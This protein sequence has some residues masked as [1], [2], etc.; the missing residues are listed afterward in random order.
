MDNNP[1]IVCERCMITYVTTDHSS[2][3]TCK[4]FICQMC[5][6]KYGAL[7]RKCDKTKCDTCHKQQRIR[8]MCSLCQKHVC[9]DCF[10][11]TDFV[12]EV[13]SKCI[14]SCEICSKFLSSISNGS[15]TME[16]P[17]LNFPH[18]AMKYES[19]HGIKLE[20]RLYV[21]CLRYQSSTYKFYVF[22]TKDQAMDFADKHNLTEHAIKECVADDSETP[23]CVKL[24]W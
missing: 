14:K 23:I 24:A 10:N 17:C 6:I 21:I 15:R 16:L 18:N 1:F 2:C 9:G 7:C 12:C 5:I 22:T 19:Y 13:C 3:Q 8:M 11:K 20:P 4:N